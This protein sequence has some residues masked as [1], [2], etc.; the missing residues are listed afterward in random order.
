MHIKNTGDHPAT[1]VTVY[2][3]GNTWIQFNDN[4]TLHPDAWTIRNEL[5]P[6]VVAETINPGLS[7]VVY[8]RAV[9]ID[10]KPHSTDLVVKGVYAFA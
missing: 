2:A 8:I 5:N 9:N 10:S 4:P 6:F 1:N 3:Y 7:A